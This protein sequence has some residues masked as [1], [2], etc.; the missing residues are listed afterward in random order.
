MRIAPVAE[1]KA[2][3][4]R[5][6]DVCAESPVV[7]TRNGRPTAV[8]VAVRDEAELERLVLWHTPR[9]R[10]ILEAADRRIEKGGGIKHGEFWKR[11]T[12]RSKTRRRRRTRRRVERAPSPVS[13]RARES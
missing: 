6:L 9:F 4:S 3:L 13:R 12:K 11:V 7:V 2:R 8:L 1:V 5:Y 10:A